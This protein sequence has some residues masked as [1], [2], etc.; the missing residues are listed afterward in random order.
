[1][2]EQT[3]D[4]AATA[5]LEALALPRRGIVHDLSSGWWHGMPVVDCHPQFNVLSYRTPR[6]LHNQ[7]DLD[8]IAE[9]NDVRF[10]FISEL[11]TGT[12]HTGTH[13]DALCHI[14]CGDDHSWHGGVSADTHLGDF[15]ALSDDA[16]TL[17]PLIARGVL[18]DVAGALGGERMPAGFGIDGALLQRTAQAQGVELRAGDVVLVRTG[19]MRDWPDLEAMA[20]SEG[21]GVDL[22]GARW[23]S[24]H[25]P[26]A[27]GAD[28]SSFE[29][30]PSQVPGNP[31]PV[32]L[33]MLRENGIP[34]M[35]WVDCEALAREQAWTFLFVA[36]PLSIRG[37]T[38]SMIRPVAIV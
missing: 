4:A 8:F 5:L 37:A 12:A 10:S 9:D 27:V 31:H 23:L 22:D 34:I 38:G 15:G 24:G 21:A 17:G 19:Q 30:L 36:L 1:M 26:A 35:E 7:R 32:H 18:L 16:S 14:T 2:S 20:P 11:M 28:T 29:Q 33:H 3:T 13:M 6:G 25:R